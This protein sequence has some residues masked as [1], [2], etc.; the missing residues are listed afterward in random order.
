MAAE[1]VESNSKEFIVISANS[2]V[3]RIAVVQQYGWKSFNI[4]VNRLRS[5]FIRVIN[6]AQSIT[7]L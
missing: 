7:L 4:E 2:D 5:I 3:R 6:L 1:L